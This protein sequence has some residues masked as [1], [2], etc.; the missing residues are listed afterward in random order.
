MS[1][2]TTGPQHCRDA[3]SYLIDLITAAQMHDAGSL[4]SPA[5][6]L[7][8]PQKVQNLPDVGTSG[9]THAPLHAMPSWKFGSGRL[10][11]QFPLP[12]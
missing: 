5:V 7:F 1:R 3:T 2:L 6:E 12:G 4:L 9:A 11:E 8:L 10:I